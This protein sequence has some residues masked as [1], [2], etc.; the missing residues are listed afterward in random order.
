MVPLWQTVFRQHAQVYWSAAM[1]ASVEYAYKKC[2]MSEWR[3]LTRIIQTGI[4]SKVDGGMPPAMAHLVEHWTCYLKVVSS[5]STDGRHFS[6]L[7]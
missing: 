2:F 3:R 5:I 6:V 7:L 1:A 4:P